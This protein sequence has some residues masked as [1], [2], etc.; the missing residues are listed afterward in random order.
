MWRVIPR[1]LAGWGGVREQTLIRAFPQLGKARVGAS[2][3]LNGK[4]S[5]CQCRRNRFDPWSGEIPQASGQLN[6]CS[7]TAD[8]AF[9]RPGAETPEPPLWRPGARGRD[10]WTHVPSSPS[11]AT[12][13]CE[14][15]PAHRD[16]RVAP[17]CLSQ[18]KACAAMKTQHSQKEVYFKNY[19]KK[20][21]NKDPEWAWR[22]RKVAIA[23]VETED[24]NY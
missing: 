17:A 7:T 23:F 11:F 8:P 14:E 16:W 21:N 9:W 5:V 22:E 24:R 3:W 15:K 6:L 20:N 10:H 1:T 12:S 19:F 4:E 18:R 13:R 2:W